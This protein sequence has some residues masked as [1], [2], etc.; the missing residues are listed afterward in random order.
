ML[1]TA[2]G[3]GRCLVLVAALT[4]V[5]AQ[6]RCQLRDVRQADG[7]YRLGACEHLLLFGALI[8]DDGAVRVAEAL[9]TN[10]RLQFLDLWSNNI[11]P[12]GAQV[13]YHDFCHSICDAPI[14][15]TPL[16]M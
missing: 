13:G 11:G 12:R 7:S 14:G 16:C 15:S 2:T 5:S 1:T 4:S 6:N 8:G 9:A 10:N 3:S